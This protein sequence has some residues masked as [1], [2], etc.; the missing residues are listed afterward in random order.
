MKSL[1][2]LDNPFIQFLARVGDMILANFLFIIC[3]LPVVTIGAALTGLNKVTQEIAM[4]NSPSLLRSFFGA[5][6]ENFRQ[7]TGAWLLILVF[8]LGMVCNLMLV[9]FYCVGVVQQI[10]QWGL[11]FIMAAMLA[12]AAYVFPL[13]VRY[14]NSLKQHFINATVLAVVKLP[15]T[16]VIVVLIALPL[17]LAYVSFPIFFRTLVFWL[18]LGYG[19]SSYVSSTLLVS[20]FRK[21]EETEEE[22]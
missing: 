15:R 3:S 12:I 10:L 18:S 20:V 1:F 13:I 4:D 22:A 19:F 17:V 7:A 2:N 11:Y 21:I 8:F 5:F 14:E 6:K 9:S 16:L